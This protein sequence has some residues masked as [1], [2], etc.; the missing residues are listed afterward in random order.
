MSNLGQTV[1]SRRVTVDKNL[2]REIIM[3]R[4]CLG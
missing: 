1:V 2:V 4:K 3:I